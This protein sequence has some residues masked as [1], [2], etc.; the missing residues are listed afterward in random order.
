M[1]TYIVHID[2]TYRPYALTYLLNLSAKYPV[3]LSSHVSNCWL[4]LV[5]CDKKYFTYC[6]GIYLYKQDFMLCNLVSLLK[7]VK[8]GMK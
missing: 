6:L 1:Y 2:Y 8:A 5:M 4:C 3:A 7:M